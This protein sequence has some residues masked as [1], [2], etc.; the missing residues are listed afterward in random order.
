M[1]IVDCRKCGKQTARSIGRYNESIKNGWNIF[2]SIECRYAFQEKGTEFCCSWCSK[3]IKKTPG[4]IRQIIT[5][6]FCSKSCA[7]RYNNRH[8]HT[9]TKRSKLECFLENQLKSNFPDLI[10]FCN[11]K[12]PIG[13][14]LD[15]YF[16]ALKLGV[17]INGILHYKPIY[18]LEK[19]KRIR[20]IDQE[21]ID[22][23]VEAGIALHIFDVSG[24]PHLTEKV[25]D[26]HWKSIK[27][28]VTSFQK[29][30]GYTDA[31]V[32]YL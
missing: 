18:G 13:S 27:E 11:T 4:Q 2:C 8:K 26:K 9:G 3:I 21:K 19:L 10:F 29:R 25:K 31:Q 16:P 28:L 12:Q 24:E 23:C 32:S 7:A 17:E 22:K 5:N 1:K 14:E 20:K 30:A 15:F 6:V